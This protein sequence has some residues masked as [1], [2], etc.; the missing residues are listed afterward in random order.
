MATATGRFL[1][2]DIKVSGAFFTKRHA[3]VMRRAIVEEIIEKMGVRMKRGGRGLGAKRNTVTQGATDN[4]LTSRISSTRR[5]PRNTGRSWVAY[6]LRVGRAMASRVG[7]KAAARA[8]GELG[9][10]G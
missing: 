6:N 5:P 4:R 7:K 3:D 10:R 9:G 1:D 2:V 8:A